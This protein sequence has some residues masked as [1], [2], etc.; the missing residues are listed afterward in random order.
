MRISPAVISALSAA[1][2]LAAQAEAGTVPRAPLRPSY[3]PAPDAARWTDLR[4]LL[5]AQTPPPTSDSIT[6]KFTFNAGPGITLIP[7]FTQAKIGERIVGLSTPVLYHKGAL[8]VTTTDALLIRKLISRRVLPPPPP[9]QRGRKMLVVID[10]GHGGHDPGA[11][12][13]GL[14]EK[15]INLN[16]GKRLKTILDANGFD[17]K[18][19]RSDDTFIPLNERAAIA[20]RSHADFFISIHSNSERSGTVTGIETYHCDRDSRFSPVARGLV[21]AARRKFDGLKLGLTREPTGEMS[22][23]LYGLLIED[24]RYQSLKLARVIQQSLVQRTAAASRG[25]KPGP[26]RV[27]RLTNCPAVLVE[28]GFL[29][30]RYEAMRLADPPYQENLAAAIARGLI[31]HAAAYQLPRTETPDGKEHAGKH[32]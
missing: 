20:N 24:A 29:S 9:R 4:R 17:V 25:I 26:F 8:F 13:H 3:A 12:G 32:P 7:G 28:T 6:H 19:T 30:N 1:L 18:L 31:K 23:I 11:I 15:D 21:A 22:R 5:P 2:C 27:L 14:R 16:V 10:P